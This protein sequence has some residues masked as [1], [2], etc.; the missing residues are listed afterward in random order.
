M[1]QYF[2]ESNEEAEEETPQRPVLVVVSPLAHVRPVRFAATLPS[3]IP[4]DAAWIKD[5][6]REARFETMS[7]P[8]RLQN[9]RDWY[10]SELGFAS[11]VIVGELEATNWLPANAIRLPLLKSRSALLSREKPMVSTPEPEI[12]PLTTFMKPEGRSRKNTK[13]FK[14]AKAKAEAKPDPVKEEAARQEALRNNAAIKIQCAWRQF[15]ARAELE[16]RRVERKL[17]QE[18]EVDAP[19]SGF[20][21]QL[22]LSLRT[23][24]QTSDLKELN[25]AFACPGKACSGQL[26]LV[27]AQLPK[28]EY[29]E[30]KGN[31]IGSLGLKRLASALRFQSSL[32]ALGLAWNGL[33]NEGCGFI[34][35]IIEKCR[36]LEHLDLG[37]NHIGDDGAKLFHLALKGHPCLTY[38]NLEDNAVSTEGVQLLLCSSE[39]RL[40]LQLHGSCVPCKQLQKMISTSKKVKKDALAAK[41]AFEA[42]RKAEQDRLAQE[43][44]KRARREARNKGSA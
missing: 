10:R 8:I 44:A 26:A 23:V 17:W 11:D 7:K 35:N 25:L 6:E 2:A 5:K 28:L 27:L 20:G 15:V 3:A 34:G 31:Y 24:A 16:K 40:E 19:E 14:K 9:C 13:G 32:R 42:A 39:L 4:D 30:L 33:G 21:S 36:Q 22:P 1:S 37:H 18:E 29:L 41:Q 12:A 38:L 43:A